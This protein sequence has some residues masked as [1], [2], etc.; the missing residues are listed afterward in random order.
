MNINLNDIH[1]K[2]KSVRDLII[3]IVEYRADNKSEVSIPENGFTDEMKAWLTRNQ[4]PYSYNTGT[5]EF[6]INLTEN[7]D[8]DNE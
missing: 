2:P 3:N 4:I 7:K 5:F 1:K 6:E 8:Q